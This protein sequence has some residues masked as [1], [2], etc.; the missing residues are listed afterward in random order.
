MGLDYGSSIPEEARKFRA[1][2]PL[3]EDPNATRV[4]DRTIRGGE[5]TPGDGRSIDVRLLRQLKIEADA[6]RSAGA[7][8]EAGVPV[9]KPVGSTETVANL[10]P[11]A[12]ADYEFKRTA[13]QVQIEAARQKAAAAVAAEMPAPGSVPE[14]LAPVPVPPAKNKGWL[15]RLGLKKA[16]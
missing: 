5:P 9:F 14:T 16:P 13:P 10:R 6:R 4:S 2:P 11:V 12:A 7:K 1:P 8:T 15:E 3:A